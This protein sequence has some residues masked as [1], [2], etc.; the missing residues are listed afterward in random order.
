MADRLS[1]VES[2]E[3]VF[4]SLIETWLLHEMLFHWGEIGWI[5]KE[6]ADQFIFRTRMSRSVYRSITLGNGD[7][8]IAIRS[9]LEDYPP[10]VARTFFAKL[11]VIKKT[12]KPDSREDWTREVELDEALQVLAEDDIVKT[13]HF[14]WKHGLTDIGIPDWWFEGEHEHSDQV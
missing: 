8:K 13:V 6:N 7:F 1:V 14:C 3:D 2:D 4:R 5:V 11:G 12:P 10:S 9:I